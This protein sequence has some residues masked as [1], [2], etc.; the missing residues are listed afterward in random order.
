[1]EFVRIINDVYFAWNC[2]CKTECDNNEVICID[3]IFAW[4]GYNIYRQN[5][6]FFSFLSHFKVDFVFVIIHLVLF[7]V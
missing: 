7:Q 5:F 2:C 3:G 1:M 6:F 4:H